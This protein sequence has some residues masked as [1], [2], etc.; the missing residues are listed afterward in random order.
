MFVEE[1]SPPTFQSL[2]DAL[3][4]STLQRGRG[5]RRVDKRSASTRLLPLFIPKR[6]LP[7]VVSGCGCSR[8]TFLS[9]RLPF[10]GCSGH[11]DEHAVE[12]VARRKTLSCQDFGRSPVTF[13]NNAI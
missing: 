13:V 11:W 5:F 1:I 4:L 2:V 10:R 6:G 8:Q 3:R 7:S 9:K 12:L